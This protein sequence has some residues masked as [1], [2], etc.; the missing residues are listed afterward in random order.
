VLVA[1]YPTIDEATARRMVAAQSAVVPPAPP[2][3][4]PVGA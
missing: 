1:A 4:A 2:A 3:P